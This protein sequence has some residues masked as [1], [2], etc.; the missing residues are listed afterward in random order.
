MRSVRDVLL[1][2]I[3]RQPDLQ[4]LVGACGT[5]PSRAPPKDSS[6][7]KLRKKVAKTLGLSVKAAEKHHS[8][9]PWRWKLVESV[10][11]KT[12]D[13]DT[14]LSEWLREGARLVSRRRSFL[15]VPCP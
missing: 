5:T 8:A 3:K 15:V 12:G 10:I 6:I 7:A 13:P 9:S 4:G 11:A 1:G 14:I 2:E